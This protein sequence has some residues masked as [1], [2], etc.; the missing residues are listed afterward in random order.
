MSKDIS[1]IRPGRPVAENPK[2]VAISFR[3]D[4][5]VAEAIEKKRQA[6]GV[7][8]FSLSDTVREVLIRSLELDGLLSSGMKDGR[9]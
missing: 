1:K 3:V 8:T 4:D 2:R 7:R 5:V 9:D 6:I